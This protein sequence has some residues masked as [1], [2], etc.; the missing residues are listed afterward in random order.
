M[1]DRN[2]FTDLACEVHDAA[3]GV[4]G[5][6]RGEYERGGMR[7]TDIRI[8]DERGQNAIGRPVGRY[9]TIDVGRLWESNG[10]RCAAAVRLFCEMLSSLAKETGADLSS[11]MVCGLGN[12]A[13]TPDA[14]GP[15]TAD[16][17]T[18]TRHIKDEE[19]G[20]VG[21]V[22]M[23]DVCA[24][25]PGVVGQTGV[26]TAEY[27]RGVCDRVKPSLIIAVD[28]LAA[29]SAGRLATTIQLTDTGIRPGSGI[30]Q[31]RREI[32]Y[33]TMGVPVIAVGVPT[34]TSCR[35]LVYDALD[36]L[37]AGEELL[38]A[39]EGREDFFVSLNESDLVVRTLAGVL[40]AGIDEFTQNI[41]AKRTDANS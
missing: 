31:K 38:R 36:G 5:V 20:R 11:V 6:E 15:F 9:I 10:E 27:L 37:R 25:C 1:A 29:R 2:I 3:G 12:R 7:I 4:D 39:L 41:S 21:L 19:R 33:Q 32:S 34:V 16:T 18:V 23:P 17:V 28:A 35:T 8:T 26:E 30:G 14:I 40:S 13:V 24:V 22:G